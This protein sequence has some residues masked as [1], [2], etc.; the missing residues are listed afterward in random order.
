MTKIQQEVSLLSSELP[1]LTLRQAILLRQHLV[2]ESAEGF[3]YK[4]VARCMAC[5]HVW[6]APVN[7]IGAEMTC[8]CCGSR[9]SMTNSRKT[10]LTKSRVEYATISEAFKG[11]QVTRTYVVEHT[12]RKDC[13]GIYDYHL[14]QECWDSIKGNVL[15]QAGKTM[16]F[17]YCREGKG[18]DYGVHMRNS[19]EYY[20]MT[21]KTE[22][23]DS[24][25]SEL[26]KRGFL[27]KNSHGFYLQPLFR[28]L[29][30]QPEFESYWKRGLYKLCDRLLNNR[31]SAEIDGAIKV[32]LR[33]NRNGWTSTSHM[34]DWFDMVQALHELGRDI[35]NPHYICPA[36][37]QEAHDRWIEA[38]RK[39][40]QEVERQQRHDEA[41]AKAKEQEEVA[42][43]YLD[44]RGKQFENLRIVGKGIIVQVLPD[45]Q[46]FIEEAD[47]MQHC[48]CQMEYYNLDKHP[49]S[50]ILSARCA[51]K[52]AKRLETVEVNL[53]NYSIVQ[54]RGRCNSTTPRHED[55]VNLVSSNMQL[56]KQYHH[57]KV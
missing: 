49:N 50:L 34:N 18:W 43:R 9:L 12:V 27:R 45:V 32:F 16:G 54:S 6:N 37:F 35:H 38:R 19:R 57:R 1:E 31:W 28:A 56:I 20:Q 13:R 17:W 2:K 39:H 40:R 29:L 52:T 41:V 55:I 11:W 46:A 8:P 21:A 10:S 3:L 7:T 24:V 51:D 42:K 15:F 26:R 30:S 36:N 23:I 47:E 22:V 4:G 33:H 14:V 48:V 44:E 53:A 25:I 5:G